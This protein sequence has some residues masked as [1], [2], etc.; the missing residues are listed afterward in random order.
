[1]R[2]QQVQSSGVRELGRLGGSAVLEFSAFS[3]SSLDLAAAM[4]DGLNSVQT[5]IT[6]LVSLVLQSINQLQCSTVRNHACG[7]AP[8]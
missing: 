7:F 2:A 5:V 8:G 3:A 1:M 4:A 6:R